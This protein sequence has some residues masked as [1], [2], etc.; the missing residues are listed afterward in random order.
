M[1]HF[2]IFF[3]FPATVSKPSVL[4]SRRSPVHARWGLAL[5]PLI[6]Q[7]VFFL[8]FVAFFLVDVGF[9]VYGLGFSYIKKRLKE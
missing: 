5:G 8:W 6:E 1:V 3:I 4:L 9:K 7:C 2:V